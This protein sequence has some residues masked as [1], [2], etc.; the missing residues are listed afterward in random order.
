VASEGLFVSLKNLTAT[1]I[2]IIYTRLDLLSTDLEE[3]RER[4]LSLFVVTFVSL[5]CLC[6]GVVLL[7]MLIVVAFWDTHRLLALATLTAVFLI[8]GLILCR[9]A[10][11]DIRAMPRMF[12]ASLTELSKDQQELESDS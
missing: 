11:R 12:A 5:F 1:L 10:L 6:I 7:A 9:I 3:G 2:A 4:L 8:A